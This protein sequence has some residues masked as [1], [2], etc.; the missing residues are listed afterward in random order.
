MTTR[1]SFNAALLFLTGAAAVSGASAQAASASIQSVFEGLGERERRLVQAE[2]L[3]AGLYSAE[4]DG[5]FGPQTEAAIAAMPDL[6][7]K[8]SA[9][10]VT[11]AWSSPAD[12]ESFLKGVSRG[13]WSRW[14]Y[15]PNC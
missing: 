4:I 5:V 8:Q 10:K 2:A 9:G 7:A 13:D 6:I 3:S 15:D 12:V 1:R 14:L 11:V